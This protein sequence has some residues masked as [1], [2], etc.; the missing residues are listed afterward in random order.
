MDDLSLAETGIIQYDWLTSMLITRRLFVS[1]PLSD[2]LQKRLSAE[3][4]QW[5]TYPVI[6]TRPGNFQVTLLFLGF[7]MEEEIPRII[8]ALEDA[9]VDIE[10]FELHLTEIK[11]EP[12][13]HPTM[14]WFSGEPSE[15]LLRLR[16]QVAESLDYLS[17]GSK[18]FRP[19]VTLAKVR[20]GKFEALETKPDFSKTLN[21]VESVD[22]ITLFE[23][24]T[25]N[26]KRVYLPL[27]E[28]PLGGEIEK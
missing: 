24:T 17:P 12:D 4:S 1:V 21:V 10:P 15:E 14:V 8:E 22:S 18:S 13:E 2:R 16:N 23:S 19:H 20:R 27:A 26:G 11:A 28:F 25:E 7:I 6:P 9:V 3:V 5:K